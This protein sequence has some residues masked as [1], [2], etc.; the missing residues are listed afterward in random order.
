MHL[1]CVVN[2]VTKT[3]TTQLIAELFP[4]P[5]NRKRLDLKSNLD[6]EGSLWPFCFFFKEINPLQRLLKPE[7][8]ASNKKKTKKS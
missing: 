8:T 7:K 6:P 2:I 4:S 3:N 1:T 5:N